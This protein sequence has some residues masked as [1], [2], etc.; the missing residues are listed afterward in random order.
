MFFP[1]ENLTILIF[2]I[3]SKTMTEINELLKNGESEKIE[4]KKS[5][6]QLERGLKAVC[7]FSNHSG[8]S[9]YFGIHGG[10]AVG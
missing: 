4:F 8:G 1:Q 7:V 5:S 9:V 10:K 6:A 2:I 3:M